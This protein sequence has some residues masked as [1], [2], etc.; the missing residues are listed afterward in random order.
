M[1]QGRKTGGRKKGTPNKRT[2]AEHVGGDDLGVKLDL[3]T[4]YGPAEY[5]DAMMRCPDLSVHARAKA[6]KDLMPY[7][8]PSLQSIAHTGDKDKPIAI[9]DQSNMIDIARRIAFVLH[10]GLRAKEV[11][12]SKPASACE[13]D[14]PMTPL[15][16]SKSL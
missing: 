11:M 14:G 16:P 12:A 13:K 2:Q 4:E 15:S 10:Q 1:A 9:V 3:P 5:L 7:K 6:A 8:H